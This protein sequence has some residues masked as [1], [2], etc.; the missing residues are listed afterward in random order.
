V[1]VP[2]VAVYDVLVATS[3]CGMVATESAL[4]YIKVKKAQISPR[5][6]MDGSGRTANDRCVNDANRW[7]TRAYDHTTIMIRLGGLWANECVV[8]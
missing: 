1:D 4:G 2:H 6:E 8:Q 7:C 3:A 5:P